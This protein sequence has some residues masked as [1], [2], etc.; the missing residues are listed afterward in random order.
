MLVV[1]NKYG[2]WSTP[3]SSKDMGG[4]ELNV[5]LS[6]QFSKG[7]EPKTDKAY[8]DVKDLFMSCF[9]SNDGIKPKMVVMD[10]AYSQKVE[11]K[12][13]KKEVSVGPDELPFY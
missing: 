8:I 3:C 12:G 4:N 9:N 5:W 6:V 7:N 11:K 1:K 13:D 2:R 10:W